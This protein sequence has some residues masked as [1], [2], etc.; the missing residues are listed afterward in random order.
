MS[1]LPAASSVT[2]SPITPVTHVGIVGG[3]QLAWMLAGAAPELGLSLRVQTPEADDPALALVG[4]RSAWVQAAVADAI[5]T[6]HLA[7][8]C[9]VVT[10]E[11]EFVDLDA[12]AAIADQGVCFRPS[13][14]SLRPL[15]DKYVQRCFFRDL[16]LPVPPF[17][18]LELGAQD[19][20][21]TWE[22]GSPLTW[23]VVIKTRRHGYDGQGTVVVRDRATWDEWAQRWR[24]VPLMVETFVPF[25]CELAA[26]AARS[27]SGEVAVY[28]I[29]ET[30]QVNQVCQ[31]VFAPAAV[32]PAIAHQATTL[33]TQLVTGL[34]GVGVF[35]IELFLTADGQVL[36]NEVA[37]RVHNSGHFSIDACITSQFAQHLRAVSDRPLGDPTLHCAG[38]VMVNLLGY[39][40]ATQDPTHAYR[41]QRDR[42][43]QFPD[44]HVYWYGKQARPGRKLGHVTA[45]DRAGAG[46]GYLEA[47]ARDLE[48]CWYPQPDRLE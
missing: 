5:A 24:A 34:G 48:A 26:L 20:P 40:N 46:R 3:G 17:V 32:D 16:G 38:A 36:I 33:A 41:E 25:A 12:L 4:D 39:E 28:P 35:G 21:P 15:I 29:V 6:G 44:A 9:Q 37:P 27:V 42:L 23:P 14:A 7:Q 19:L 11:N 43:A 47:I 8:G 45:L 18:A 1:S 22:D 31:R 30:Q 10:F 13:L 2:T